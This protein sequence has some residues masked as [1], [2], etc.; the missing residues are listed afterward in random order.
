MHFPFL[1]HAFCV[2]YSAFHVSACLGTEESRSDESELRSLGQGKIF[3][4]VDLSP[5]RRGANEYSRIKIQ[6]AAGFEPYSTILKWST[7]RRC[8]LIFG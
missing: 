1:V 4:E 8:L 5:K 6:K 3:P 2:S 7:N